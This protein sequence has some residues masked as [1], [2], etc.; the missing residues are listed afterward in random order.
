MRVTRRMAVKPTSNSVNAAQILAAARPVSNVGQYSSEMVDYRPEGQRMDEGYSLPIRSITLTAQLSAG[1]TIT[2]ISLDDACGILPLL[3]IGT[4]ANNQ[5][6]DVKGSITAA[7]LKT[8]LLTYKM[9]I[10]EINYECIEDS[11][12]LDNKIK[13]YSG[14]LDERIGTPALFDTA[15]DKRNTQ[16]QTTLQTVFPSSDAWL[17]N[18]SGIVVPTSSLPASTKTISLTLKFDKIM[19]Y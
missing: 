2:E 10:S 3:G 7:A 17:T 6:I 13:F 8:Y 12:Q 14:S 4:G 9:R 19:A 1:A 15:V 16:F 18:V 5:K 11:T